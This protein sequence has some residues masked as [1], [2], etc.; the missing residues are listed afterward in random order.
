VIV[1]T[2]DS[3]IAVA[4]DSIE[5]AIKK[6]NEQIKSL[7]EK[8]TSSDKDKAQQ[9]ALTKI[10]KQLAEIAKNNTRTIVKSDGDGKTQTR[11]VIRQVENIKTSPSSPEKKAEI[12]KARARIKELSKALAAA[13]ADLAK[14]EG[15]PAQGFVFFTNPGDAT[16]ADARFKVMALPKLSKENLNIVVDQKI[17]GAL[18]EAGKDG[19]AGMR[20][21]RVVPDVVGRVNVAPMQDV[22][23]R[24]LKSPNA[25]EDRIQ[26]LEKKLNQ[27]LEEVASLKKS[28]GD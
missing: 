21:T 13:Q 23:V 9:E 11:Y 26:A 5:D 27:L 17:K 19:K 28:K 15:H 25:A 18:A 3:A 20:V 12:E 1:K 8:S 24:A 22:Q 16:N 2:D 7:K 14:L 10:A 4:A 6:I